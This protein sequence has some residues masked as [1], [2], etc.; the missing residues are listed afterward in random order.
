MKYVDL[1]P[2]FKDSSLAIRGSELH[3]SGR[4]K[5][6][7]A[8]ALTK[9]GGGAAAGGRTVAFADVIKVANVAGSWRHVGPRRYES[10]SREASTASNFAQQ[11][12]VYARLPLVNGYL[13]HLAP[14]LYI[15]WLSEVLDK[16][17]SGA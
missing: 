14:S 8:A 11:P 12:L 3:S 6:R 9:P 17:L 7:S 15:F 4:H 16:V 13:L 1:V 5:D 10:D 2:A